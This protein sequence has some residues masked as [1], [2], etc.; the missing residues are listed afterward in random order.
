MR[1]AVIA[2]GPG[3]DKDTVNAVV[4][5]CDIVIAADSGAAVAV[6]CG[7]VPQKVTGDMDSLNADIA[8]FLRNRGVEFEVYPVEKDMSDSELCL[9]SV[10]EDDEI[11]WVCSMAGRPDHN[12]ANLM[13]A[14]K[15]H[16]EGRSIT[17]TDG[18]NDFIPL[19][20]PDEIEFSGVLNDDDLV[21]S[22]I[23]FTNVT[24]VTSEGLYYKLDNKDLVPG[25]TLSI[26]NKLVEGADSFSVKIKSG[27][28]GVLLVRS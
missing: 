28:L 21:I 22:L 20:G 18:I 10:P 17:V 26:S 4:S 3:I 2:G 1:T 8:D 16:E 12:L 23:P 25:S 5:S 15:L 14:V 27:N 19:S 24:G 11:I 13:L 7:I 9:R 6:S